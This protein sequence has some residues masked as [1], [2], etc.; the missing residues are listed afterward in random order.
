MVRPN[1]IKIPT[2]P[3]PPRA[4]APSLPPSLP[5]SLSPCFQTDCFAAVNGSRGERKRQEKQE[6]SGGRNENQDR[7]IHWD[8]SVSASRH[9]RGPTLQNRRSRRASRGG[10]LITSAL[11]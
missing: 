5:P 10:A 3:P 11:R 2:P 9:R 4:P 8:L 7:Q 6:D 1:R